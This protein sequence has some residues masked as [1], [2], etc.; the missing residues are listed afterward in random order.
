MNWTGGR[1]QRH[2]HNKPGSLSRIQKQHFAKARLKVHS[3]FHQQS[4]IP[5]SPPVLVSRHPPA[6]EKGSGAHSCVPSARESRAANAL[7]I[8][9]SQEDTNSGHLV[10]RQVKTSEEFSRKSRE[11][12]T[13]H[14][15]QD[16]ENTEGNVR[17]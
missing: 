3:E 2:S 11:Q 8:I 17:L 10:N 5:F 4:Q 14:F 15:R 9:D 13:L 16:P 1:L 7:E 6:P 12:E